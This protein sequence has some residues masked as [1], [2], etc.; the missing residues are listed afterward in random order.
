MISFQQMDFKIIFFSV[1]IASATIAI[2][3]P[4][5]IE[6][7]L[8]I[9]EQ[10]L[11]YSNEAAATN[12]DAILRVNIEKSKQCNIYTLKLLDKNSGKIIKETETCSANLPNAA[13]QNAVFEIFGYPVENAASGLSGNIKTFLFGTGFV[14][15][16]VL[17]YYSNTPKPVYGYSKISEE[18][19]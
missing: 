17:L 18:E 11:A 15:A 19:K 12:R 16:G 3:Q 6:S 10:V 4:L 14:A 9:A 5:R 13:L 2:A 8:E 7:P 1:L